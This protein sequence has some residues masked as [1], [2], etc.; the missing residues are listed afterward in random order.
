M[1]TDPWLDRIDDS[2][3]SEDFQYYDSE[4]D[5]YDEND[6]E[7]IQFDPSLPQKESQEQ[8]QQPQSQFY[9]EEYESRKTVFEHRGSIQLEL[10]SEE[11]GEEV[12]SSK[13]HYLKVTERERK[14]AAAKRE[15]ERG[16]SV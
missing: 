6:Q 2:D 14:D 4:S 5:K 15:R 16:M 7:E 9:E 13:L 11:E 3:E 8:P 12:G 10:E 1:L